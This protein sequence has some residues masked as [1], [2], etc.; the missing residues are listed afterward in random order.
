[1]FEPRGGF[2]RWDAPVKNDAIDGIRKEIASLIERQQRDLE[3]ATYLGM[4]AHR[5]AEHEKRRER[6]NHLLRE[7]ERLQGTVG[8]RKIA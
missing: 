1:M 7:L 2:G 6:I 3:E 4:T 5:S 8:E